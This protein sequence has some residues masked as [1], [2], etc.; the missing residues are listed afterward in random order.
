[1]GND[2]YFPEGKMAGAWSWPLTPPISLHGVV[3]S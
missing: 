2:G 3:L 1:M